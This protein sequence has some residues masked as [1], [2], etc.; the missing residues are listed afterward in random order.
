MR[1]EQTPVYS[2]YGTYTRMDVTGHFA[3]SDF[4]LSLELIIADICPPAPIGRAD[5]MPYGLTALLG[6]PR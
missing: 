5:R 6:A 2:V 3:P 1:D 4:C